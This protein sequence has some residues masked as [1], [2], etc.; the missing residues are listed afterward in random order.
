MIICELTS[1][2]GAHTE[3]NASLVA[4]ARAAF[5]EQP[6]CFI[7]ART[8][9]EAVEKELARYGVDGVVFET[10]PDNPTRGR[11]Q[12][13]RTI[14]SIFRA[15]RAH[16]CQRILVGGFDRRF[17]NVF[18]LL[19]PRWFKGCCYGLVHHQG[20]YLLDRTDG[21]AR[22][23]LKARLTTLLWSKR[24][25]VMVLGP[26]VA[27]YLTRHSAYP[28]V[29][30]GWVYHPYFY[31]D[32]SGPHPLQQGTIDFAF[33]GRTGKDK[34]FDVFCRLADRVSGDPDAG[35]CRF[36]LI[37]PLHWKPVEFSDHGP[38]L[39]IKKEKWRLDREEL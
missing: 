3:I 9:L 24:V 4:L 15:C 1:F 12:L 7:A 16:R 6:V 21:G 5:P 10:L 30:I 19:M 13:I 34:G 14:R 39:R 35:N 23:G 27:D 26:T 11:L 25:R 18:S 38:V 32:G 2:F 28:A 31:A 22:H 8:H 29:K 17:H 33:L 20:T 36:I 37:G